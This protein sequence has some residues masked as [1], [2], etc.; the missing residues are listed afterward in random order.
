MKGNKAS[1][2]GFGNVCTSGLVGTSRFLGSVLG[3]PLVVTPRKK[4][5]G[6]WPPS[7]LSIFLGS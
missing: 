7:A 6:L 4:I 5:S 1:G 3:S 2:S